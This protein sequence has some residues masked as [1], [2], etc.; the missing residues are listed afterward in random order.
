MI[1]IGIICLLCLVMVSMGLVAA[2]DDKD[3][4]DIVTFVVLILA[5]AFFASISFYQAGRREIKTKVRPEVEYVIKEG[6]ET[7]DTTYIYH[8]K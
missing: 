7:Q 4:P 1:A 5:C 3:N 2:I 8:F 6:S